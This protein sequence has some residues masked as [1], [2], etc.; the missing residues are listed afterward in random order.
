MDPFLGMIA[1]FGFN[2]APKGWAVCNGQQ[3]PIQSN[4]ALFA[5]FF[6]A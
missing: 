1:M 3:L 5:L 6:A 2:F 4:T